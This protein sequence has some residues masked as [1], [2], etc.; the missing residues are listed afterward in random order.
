MVDV[1]H[2]LRKDGGGLGRKRMVS[3]LARLRDVHAILRTGADEG[4]WP[5]LAL[6]SEDVLASAIAVARGFAERGGE[7]AVVGQPGAVAAV[8][9]VVDALGVRRPVWVDS[10]DDTVLASL[11]RPDVDWLVL[12]GPAWAD[13]VAEWA[14]GQDR[15]VAVAGPGEHAAPPGGWWVSDAV[16]GDG[17][18]APFGPAAA[19]AASWSGVDVEELHGGA[20]DMR[21]ACERS[22]LFENPAY[23]LAL[24]TVFAERDLAAAV[25][26]HLVTVGRLHAFAGWIT[27]V[28]GAITSDAVP[29]EGVVRHAGAAGV[30][31][32]VGDEE[33]LQALLVGPRDKLVTLWDTTELPAGPLASELA[34]QAR[35]VRE[36]LERENVPYV[37]VRLPGLDARAAGGAALLAA[38]AAVTAAVFQDVDPLGLGGVAAWYSTL[39]RARA[40]VDAARINA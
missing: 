16:A 30:P 1:A 29:G 17:R 38:H 8:R 4:R 13:R 20:R 32:V 34:A 40:D 31:G 2:L 12:E 27:R 23:T 3:G 26:V 21:A 7:L 35:A 37:R 39:E 18:F 24:A 28:W 9:A 10:P 11:D 25:P 33:L 14:V 22:A 36:L 6:P 5:H 15:R 19:I